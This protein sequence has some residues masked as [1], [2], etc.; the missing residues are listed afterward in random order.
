MLQRSRTQF[1]YWSLA[2]K[3]CFSI[4]RFIEGLSSAYD[5]IFRGKKLGYLGPFGKYFVL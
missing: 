5:V 4:V 2:S 1:G 3:Q